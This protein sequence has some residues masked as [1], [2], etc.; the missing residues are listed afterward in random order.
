MG[1]IEFPSQEAVSTIYTCAEYQPFLKKRKAGL[2]TH[3]AFPPGMIESLHYIQIHVIKILL[4]HTVVWQVDY[5]G[6]D[7]ITL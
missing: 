6:I 1:L 5:S 7:L 3:P 2:F 4:Q